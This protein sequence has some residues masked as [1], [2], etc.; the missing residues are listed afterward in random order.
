[1]KVGENQID[2][3]KLQKI[4]IYSNVP[5]YYF[6]FFKGSWKDKE[7]AITEQIKRTTTSEQLRQIIKTKGDLM[8]IVHLTAILDRM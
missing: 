3:F 7:Y 5:K 8:N 1:M 4:G 6:G 2:K